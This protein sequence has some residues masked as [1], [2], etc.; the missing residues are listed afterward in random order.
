M[1]KIMYSLLVLLL[2]SGTV[3]AHWN[4]GDPYKWLQRPDLTQTG[5]DICV[6]NTGSL[7]PRIIGD[8]FE[9]RVT[10]PITDVHLWGSWKND[11]KGNITQI[12]VSFYSDIPDPNPQDPQDY[13][14]PGTLLWSRTFDP[15]QFT[16]R[17]YSTLPPQQFEWWW[18]PRT[19]TLLPNGDTQVWQYNIAIPEDPFIQEGTPQQPV[20]YW[21]VI[22]VKIDPI[23]AGSSFGW[24]TRDRADGWFMDKAVWMGAQW[25]DIE[26]PVGHPYQ[27]D[28]VDMAFVL[29]SGQQPDELDFGDA[30]DGLTIPGY[31]TLLMNNGARHVIRGPW[32]GDATDVP[33]P[34]P[35][36]QPMPPAGGDDNDGN[37]DEDGVVIPILMPGISNTI[38]VTVS[39][40]A[41]AGGVVQMWIDWNQDN[42]WAHP[43]ELVF[44]GFLPV[45]THSIPVIA[46]PGSI[47]QTY[48]RARISSQGGLFPYGPADDGEVEDHLVF[49]EEE[50]QE[51]LDFGDAPPPYPTLLVVNGAHHFIVPGVFMGATIDAEPDGQPTIPADGDDI[52]PLGSPNDEDGV[53]FLTP[54]VAGFPAQV[55]VTVSVGGFLDAWIDFEKNGNWTHPLEQIFTSLPLPAGTHTLTFNVP[56]GLGGGVT[57]PVSYARFRFSTNGGLSYV[58]WAPD[59]EVEDYQVF[60][61]GEIEDVADLGD[62]PDSTNSPGLLMSAYPGVQANFPTVYG[63]GSPPYGPFHW[64]PAGVAYLGPQV[65]YEIEADVGPDQDVVNNINPISDT[66]DHDGNDDSVLNMPLHL[67][68]CDYTTFDYTVNI[69]AAALN[70]TLYVNAWFDWNRDGDWDDA[71]SVAC[72][73]NKGMNEW[74]VQNQVITGLGP[75]LHTLRTPPF[76]SWHPIFDPVAPQE[77][78]MRI[79]MSEKPWTPTSGVPGDGGSGPAAGYQLGETED[80]LFVPDTTCVRCSDLNCS[81]FVD[82]L[83]FAIFAA[84][85]L[86]TCP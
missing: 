63:A 32:L 16:E 1:K 66:A 26:Y 9:C 68:Y 51:D 45:G 74:A 56:T 33:D 75:G 12:K 31:P 83:D 43:G 70:Q 49:I 35:D 50:P 84:K 5:V 24:K 44:G 79:T 78:W 86:T 29:T 40:A 54:L 10:E 8:D 72:G 37:D 47:G 82:F 28:H 19:G 34:E 59:G 53:V 57:N 17:L 3:W 13:S 36:G 2:L 42:N 71:N 30:P 39:D 4:E 14:M 85:W 81:G 77:I 25:V 22:E 80:Y 65:T 18:D 64:Q 41:G 46:P 20:I 23:I 27:G 21:L 69:V 15:S 61:E 6:D 38:Q 76:L 55:Q 58:G 11:I 73:P 60:I 62:A 7:G 67:P 52:R 48:L